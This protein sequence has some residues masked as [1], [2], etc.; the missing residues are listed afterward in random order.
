MTTGLDRVQ[1]GAS[2]VD[3]RAEPDAVRDG[4]EP[5]QATVDFHFK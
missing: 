2:D 3:R 5:R 4:G 1:R